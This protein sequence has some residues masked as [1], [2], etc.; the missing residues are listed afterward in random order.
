MTRNYDK[1]FKLNAVKLCLNTGK[2]Y[3]ELSENLG[4]PA[5]TISGWVASYKQ[6]GEESFPGKGKLAESDTEIAKLR[7]QLSIVKEERDILKKALGIFSAV[8][9]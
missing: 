3:R 1:E 4:V 2:S 9:R 5:A 8:R 7:K 6:K